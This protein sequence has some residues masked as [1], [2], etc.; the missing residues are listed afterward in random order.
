MRRDQFSGN[1]SVS[2][3]PGTRKRKKKAHHKAKRTSRNPRP[4]LLLHSIRSAPG[5][6]MRKKVC[7][8]C[9]ENKWLTE[10]YINHKPGRGQSYKSE[11]KRCGNER[12]RLRIARLRKKKNQGGDPDYQ[13]YQREYYKKNRE[14]FQEYRRKFLIRNPDYFKKKSRERHARLKQ[15][16]LDAKAALNDKDCA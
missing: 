4:T 8:R 13:A 6:R 7:T 10:F 14:R 11:C 3:E 9:K 2:S 16:R 1:A 12:S 15:Q 5:K